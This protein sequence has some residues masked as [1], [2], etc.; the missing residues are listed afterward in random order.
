MRNMSDDS[1]HVDEEQPIQLAL[2]CGDM[3]QLLR[4]QEK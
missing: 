4:W 3:D 1:L 2:L